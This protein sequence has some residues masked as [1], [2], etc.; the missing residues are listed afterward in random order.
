MSCSRTIRSRRRDQTWRYGGARARS[1]ATGKGSPGPIR[2]SRRYAPITSPWPVRRPKRALTRYRRPASGARTNRPARGRS[3]SRRD[4]NP[5]SS[6]TGYVPIERWH[7]QEP[8]LPDGQGIAWCSL[9]RPIA[10]RFR[11]SMA[12][13][14][15]TSRSSSR[16]PISPGHSVR[17][18]RTTSRAA[19]EASAVRAPALT[20]ALEG[21]GHL[22]LSL[23]PVPW[24]VGCARTAKASDSESD[25][26]SEECPD[27]HGDT[28]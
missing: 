13:P 14:T 16:R 10:G 5:G 4:A 21:L 17:S 23:R 24:L 6:G 15:S 18:R 20:V 1:T 22:R 12:H 7:G 19:V 27:A 11:D 28:Q 26:A 25:Q 2:T 9:T 8:A 3:S